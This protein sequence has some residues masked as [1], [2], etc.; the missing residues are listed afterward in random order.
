MQKH[1]N[2][3]DLVESFLTSIYLQKSASIQPRTRPVKFARSPCTDSP[4]LN[5]MVGV[6]NLWQCLWPPWG[7]STGRRW[8]Q[9][10]VCHRKEDRPTSFVLMCCVRKISRQLT[11][12]AFSSRR[13]LK[14]ARINLT[15]AC[16]KAQ[17]DGLSLICWQLESKLLF[18]CVV[19]LW[20]YPAR[21][22]EDWGRR[23]KNARV[24]W[25]VFNGE[26][27]GRLQF[28]FLRLES[29]KECLLFRR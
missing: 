22:A 13:K 23:P 1:V 15:I 16:D 4:G 7:N 26:V 9:R 24:S 25:N 17:P 11:L 2:H 8:K 12:W 27:E 19:G 28:D 29:A 20:P 14:S 18:G 3:V 5:V 21:R 6:A 10:R